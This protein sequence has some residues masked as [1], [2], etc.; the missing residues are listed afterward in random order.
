MGKLRCKGDATSPRFQRWDQSLVT[1]CHGRGRG[2]S[3]VGAGSE[4]FSPSPNEATS[5]SRTSQ[6]IITTMKRSMLAIL[7][8]LLCGRHKVPYVFNPH[9]SPKKCMLLS[10]H[11]IDGKTEAQRAN[12]IM[13]TQLVCG[14]TTMQH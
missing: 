6:R 5:L 14:S 10:S 1:A 7:E 9:N 12:V 4:V 8:C 13:A 3:S 11:Y 2:T